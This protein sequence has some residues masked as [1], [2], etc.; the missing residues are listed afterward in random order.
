[1]VNWKGFRKKKSFSKRDILR[2]FPE[3]AKESNENLK[4]RKV[5]SF[6]I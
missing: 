1:M 5:S 4:L 6:V 3:G 2:Y